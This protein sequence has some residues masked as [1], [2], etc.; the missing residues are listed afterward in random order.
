MN[1]FIFN[2]GLEKQFD[3]KENEVL[4]FEMEVDNEVYPVENVIDFDTCLK[5]SEKESKESKKKLSEK[6]LLTKIREKKNIVQALQRCRKGKGF[7]CLSKKKKRNE[8][9]CCS[10][11]TEYQRAYGAGVIGKG[12]KGSIRL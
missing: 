11:Q 2:D 3:D 5:P 10:T 9:S 8:C 12:R 1:A 7:S 6:G 4:E